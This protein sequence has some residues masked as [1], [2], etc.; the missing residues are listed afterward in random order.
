MDPEHTFEVT[1]R[2]EV[3]IPLANGAVP[4]FVTFDGFSNGI[5]HFAL[6]F[7]RDTPK[8]DPLV[9]V[10]SECITGDVFASLRCDC[11]AQLHEAMDLLAIEGGYLLYLRQ[12]GRGIGLYN[13]LDAYLLQNQGLDTYAA[14]RQLKLPDDARDFGCAAAMLKAMA[15]PRIRL[16]SN[17][18][19]KATQLAECGI[20]ITEN[21]PTQTFANP[22]NQRYL[23]AKASLSGHS[24][25]LIAPTA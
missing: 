6:R 17:N 8:G 16:L 15:I 7:A 18:P 23:A 14:N 1:V 12:E 22:H 24:L 13:K 20:E 21:I 10:H 4:H 11:G 2:A 9:R 25:Q 5:E 19:G 3:A